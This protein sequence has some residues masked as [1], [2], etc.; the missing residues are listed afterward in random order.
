M[1]FL[2]EKKQIKNYVYNGIET[3]LV[4]YFKK[5]LGL[6]WLKKNTSSYIYIYIYIYIY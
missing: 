2:K 1:W 6:E 3:I 4:F 5:S